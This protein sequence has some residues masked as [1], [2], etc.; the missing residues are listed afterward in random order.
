MPLAVLPPSVKSVRKYPPL[1]VFVASCTPLDSVFVSSLTT[2]SVFFASFTA[3]RLSFVP[4]GGFDPSLV[5]TSIF[6]ICPTDPTVF[7][8]VIGLFIIIG[9]VSDFPPGEGAPVGDED[10]VADEVPVDV[11]FAASDEVTGAGGGCFAKAD[12]AVLT[13]KKPTTRYM[14]AF[15]WSF[16]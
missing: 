2:A 10:P 9:L 3:G 15:T 11:V 1:K 4:T 5:L 12:S 14:P 16:V 13:F 6:V 7:F 8:V